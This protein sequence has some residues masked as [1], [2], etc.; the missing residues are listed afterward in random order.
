MSAGA[1][2]NSFKKVRSI[3]SSSPVLEEKVLNCLLDTNSEENENQIFEADFNQLNISDNESMQ[4][5]DDDSISEAS[6][7]NL[8]QKKA[9]VLLQIE[10]ENPAMIPFVRYVLSKA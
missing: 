3:N 2:N 9:D 6:R 7:T 10:C 4:Q 5:N 1:H 8:K